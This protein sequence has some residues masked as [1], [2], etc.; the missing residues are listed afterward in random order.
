M[1]YRLEALPFEEGAHAPEPPEIPDEVPGLWLRLKALMHRNRLD[2]DLADELQFHVAMSGEPRFGN[3]ALLK[4]ECREQWT[5]VWI[6]TLWQDVRFGTR[7]LRRAPVLTAAAVRCPWRWAS[8]RQPL[9]IA[10]AIRCCGVRVALPHVESLAVVLQGVPGNPHSWSPAAPADIADLRK[11]SITVD[12]IAS[13]AYG[14]A[15]LAAEGRE[16]ARVEQVRVTSDFFLYSGFSR[17]WA[18]RFRQ[19]MTGWRS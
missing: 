13:W 1:S 5:F 9:S 4:E 18:G 11:A 17:R 2:Q 7:Q 14:I 16:A 3:V 15:N 6:E 10:C 19:G 12:G 8:A